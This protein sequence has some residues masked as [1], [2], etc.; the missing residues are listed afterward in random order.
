MTLKLALTLDLVPRQRQ[1]QRRPCVTR[2]HPSLEHQAL[3]L[4]VHAAGLSFKGLTPR[5]RIS[6]LGSGL[7]DRVFALHISKI[8]ISFL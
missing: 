4:P 8:L 2:T 5:S 3:G 6:V 1:S 7:W